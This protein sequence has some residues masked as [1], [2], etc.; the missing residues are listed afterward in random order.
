MNS[1]ISFSLISINDNDGF[2]GCD[3]PLKMIN[4]PKPEKLIKEI[5]K[6]RKCRYQAN[7]FNCL[8]LAA[9]TQYQGYVCANANVSPDESVPDIC[10]WSENACQAGSLD[11]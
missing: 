7:E 11:M 3:K 4:I 9:I 6:P 8:L 10:K 5:G 1:A 2:K